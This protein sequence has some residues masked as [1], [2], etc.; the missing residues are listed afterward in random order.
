[1]FVDLTLAQLLLLGLGLLLFV[2]GLVYAL[3]PKIVEQLLEA[4]RDMPLEAR[5]LIG[6]LSMLSGLGLLWFLS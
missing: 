4:L 1:M 6:L 3:F 5:R 2:E